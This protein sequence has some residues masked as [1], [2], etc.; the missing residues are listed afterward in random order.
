M[1]IPVKQR[2][3]VSIV[4]RHHFGLHPS[5]THPDRGLEADSESSL[6][7]EKHSGGADTC[8]VWW[9]LIVSA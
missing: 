6:E 1:G 4:L 8:R 9:K 2:V 3:Q 7:D 5:M